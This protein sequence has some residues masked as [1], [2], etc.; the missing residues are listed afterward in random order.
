M[1][2]APT[3]EAPSLLNLVTIG[4]VATATIV[5][6]FGVG[7]LLLSLPNPATQPADPAPASDA[8]EAHQAP[9]PANNDTPP[10]ASAALP[11]NNVAATETSGLQSDPEAPASASIAIATAII[12]PARITR[13]KRITISRHRHEPTVRRSMVVWHLNAYPGPNPGGG[14][15]GAPNI[16]VGQI[17]PK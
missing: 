6:F 17:N 12:R 7:F 8:L 10:S 2:T 16:N 11:A 5:V 9:L 13:T 4:A 15:Y 1:T 3:E 14:F